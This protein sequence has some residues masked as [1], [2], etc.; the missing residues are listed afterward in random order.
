MDSKS[1]A[2]RRAEAIA[3][4]T[5]VGDPSVSMMAVPH[6]TVLPEAPRSNSPRRPA[7]PRA[8][9]AR[10]KRPKRLTLKIEVVHGDDGRWLA[11]V[12]ALPGIKAHGKDLPDALVKVT[13]LAASRVLELREQ[14][15]DVGEVRF[16]MSAA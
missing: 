1:K 3:W 14:G 5:G 12:P 15:V 16:S 9:E 11:S 8:K 2:A 13:S 10:P 4:A 6:T 7:N